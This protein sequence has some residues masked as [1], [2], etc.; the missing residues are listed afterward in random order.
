MST[1]AERLNRVLALV[2]WLV[3]HNGITLTEAAAHFGISTKQLEDDLWLLV[4]SGLPGYGPDHLVDI[5]FWDDG[6]INVLDPQTIDRPLRLSS[7]EAFSLLLGLRTLAQLSDDPSITSAM[8]KLE[9]ATG[10]A[11]GVE[12]VSGPV[13]DEVLEI[14]REASAEHAVLRLL[15]AGASTDAASERDIEPLRLVASA[16]HAYVE[17]WCRNAEAMRTFRI[18]RILSVTRTDERFSPRDSQATS[19]MTPELEVTLALDPSAQW[20]AESYADVTNVNGDELEAVIR[21]ADPRW[22]VRLVLSLA[23]AAR[24]VS[25]PEV[26]QAVAVEAAAALKAYA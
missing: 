25:P 9:A 6:R 8:T 1:A 4:V 5:Q 26:A 15:Y 3:T 12:V 10:S 14:V 21:V 11:L 18:D 7:A 22:I 24:V 17:A 23:G 20:V 2:P 13:T 16:D 19:P